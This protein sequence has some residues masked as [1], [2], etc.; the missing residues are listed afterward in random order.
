M[1]MECA[2]CGREWFTSLNST[3]CYT[4]IY[5][6]NPSL[7]DRVHVHN[8][9]K[10]PLLPLSCH[11]IVSGLQ[12]SGLKIVSFVIVLAFKLF[13]NYHV[14]LFSPISILFFSSI[15]IYEAAD[16]CSCKAVGDVSRSACSQEDRQARWRGTKCSNFQ[17]TCCT[18]RNLVVVVE[19]G[20]GKAMYGARTRSCCCYC[21]VARRSQ[22]LTSVYTY[23]QGTRYSL[24]SPPRISVSR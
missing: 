7:E 10:R 2:K 19:E 23:R 8:I 4:A 20:G 15:P 24:R 13:R 11:L 3:E 16:L 12:T 18:G 17:G 14:F 1:L 22:K 5:V 6:Y 9:C 21:R